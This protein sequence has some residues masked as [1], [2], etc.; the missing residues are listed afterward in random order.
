MEKVTSKL[1]G[2]KT[3][4]MSLKLGVVI[5]LEA[6]MRRGVNAGSGVKHTL[7]HILLCF[8]S[9]RRVRSIFSVF[10]K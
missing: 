3:A 10:V 5:I 1:K 8:Q 9:I 4:C 2:R 6:V 7:N